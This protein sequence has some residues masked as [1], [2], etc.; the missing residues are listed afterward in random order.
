MQ[1][2]PIGQIAVNVNDNVNDNDNVINNNIEK[3]K[4]NFANS[5]K[6]FLSTYDKEILHNFYYYWSEHGVNDKKMRFEKEKSFDISLRLKR[7]VKND[8]NINRNETYIPKQ[9]KP[10]S[11]YDQTK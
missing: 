8:K 9:S 3:R 4:I 7:W 1:S 5:L 6:D 10:I 11:Y 2:Q